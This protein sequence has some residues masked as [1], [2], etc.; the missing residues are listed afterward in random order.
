MK[1]KNLH[2]E[3]PTLTLPRDYNDSREKQKTLD[4]LR[5]AKTVFVEKAR[6]R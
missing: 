2:Q 1:A 4:Y 3:P 5:A 6:S